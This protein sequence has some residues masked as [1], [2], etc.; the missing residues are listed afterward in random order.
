MKKSSIILSILLSVAISA[1]TY[2][3]KPFLQDYADKYE[4]NENQ[5]DKLLQVR[6]DRNNV[7]NVLS[8]EGLMK[9]WEKKI[10]KEMLY[11]PLTDMNI[12]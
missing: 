1:Q 3:D 11:R 12:L 9:P 10:V 2:I 4:L 6:S 7:I 8:S 5:S